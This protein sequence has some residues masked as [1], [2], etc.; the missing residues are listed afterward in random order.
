MCGSEGVAIGELSAILCLTPYMLC[1]Q[2]WARP[3]FLMK[4]T[5]KISEALSELLIP[6]FI[7]SK[8]Q[9]HTIV[10]HNVLVITISNNLFSIFVFNLVIIV[11]VI[12]HI[13]IFVGT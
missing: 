2:D 4:L 8:Q 6:F 1:V 12:K 13:T 5:P 3:L 7:S 11:I 9:W 10:F